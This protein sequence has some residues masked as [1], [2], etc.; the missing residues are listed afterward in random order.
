M[1]S[2]FLKIVELSGTLGLKL[3]WV[4]GMLSKITI[5]F[6]HKTFGE[7]SNEIKKEIRENKFKDT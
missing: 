3:A 6:I 5:M 7:I 4:F 2:F 1:G